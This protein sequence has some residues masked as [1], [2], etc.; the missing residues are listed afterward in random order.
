ML[1]A[2]DMAQKCFSYPFSLSIDKDTGHEVNVLL[3]AKSNI[4][5]SNVTVFPLKTCNR[6][7]VQPKYYSSEK[8]RCGGEGGTWIKSQQNN[9]V[10]R[11]GVYTP[12]SLKK[13]KKKTDAEQVI[14]NITM[15]AFFFLSTW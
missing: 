4:S 3:S 10:G 6:E 11:F 2:F 1:A 9:E 13:L 12:W 14:S 5:Q 15:V 7:K 8:K